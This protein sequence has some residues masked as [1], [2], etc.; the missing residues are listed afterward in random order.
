M[1]ARPAE[2]DPAATNA[3]QEGLGGQFDAMRTS[4]VEFIGTTISRLLDGSS[5]YNG[6]EA[7]PVDKPGAKWRT[8]ANHVKCQQH[9]PLPG[10]PPGSGN[11]G[12]RYRRR[13]VARNNP[14]KPWTCSHPS[15]QFMSTACPPRN[16]RRVLLG[17]RK[18]LCS[19]TKPLNDIKRV[20][21]WLHIH[22]QSFADP[23]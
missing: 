22:A 6:K 11:R 18:R 16:T 23:K 20:S 10:R 4:H 7:D 8:T 5:G 9:S 17:P 15:H 1:R 21:S 12:G 3:L 2:P 19:D 14:G 13:H